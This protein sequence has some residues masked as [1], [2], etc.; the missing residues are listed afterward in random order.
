M[1]DK[2]LAGWLMKKI[3]DEAAII[4]ALE[5]RGAKLSLDLTGDRAY[6]AHVA[7]KQAL[8]DVLQ[9]LRGF[10]GTAPRVRSTV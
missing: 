4:R 8:E 9:K 2:D 1:T 7:Y 6:V 10:D 3:Q 5:D